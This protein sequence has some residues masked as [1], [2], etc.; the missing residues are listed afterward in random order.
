MLCYH[1]GTRLD[2]LPGPRRVPTRV[3]LRHMF[4]LH[5]GISQ[6]LTPYKGLKVGVRF[7][8]DQRNALGIAL[9]FKSPPLPP[10]FGEQFFFWITESAALLR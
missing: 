9:R 6:P 10:L 1:N 2:S 3:Q 8:H 5:E 4:P 7:R